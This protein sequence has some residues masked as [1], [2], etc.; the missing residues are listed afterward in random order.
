MVVQYLSKRLLLSVIGALALA[1]LGGT[2]IGQSQRIDLQFEGGR[3]SADIQEAPLSDIFDRIRNEKGVWVKGV[4]A[5]AQQQVSVQ[6]QDLPLEEGIGRILTGINYSLAFDENNRLIG[7][8]LL[9]TT[10]DTGRTASGRSD[11]RRRPRTRRSL[12]R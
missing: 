7:I 12:R 2:A 5:S 11:S 1:M 3:I 9:G 10:S 4:D 6:F 8:T